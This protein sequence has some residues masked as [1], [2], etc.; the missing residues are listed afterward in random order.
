MLWRRRSGL[1]S[2]H[3]GKYGQTQLSVLKGKKL[4][5]GIKYSQ[6]NDT[7]ASVKYVTSKSRFTEEYTNE[8]MNR[9]TALEEVCK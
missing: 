4:V 8:I 1:R 9:D 5:D 2:Q 3:G 6:L 7:G